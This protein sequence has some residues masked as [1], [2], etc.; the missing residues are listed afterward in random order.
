MK[1]KVDM[2]KYLTNGVYP[3]V[4]G[5]LEIMG[6]MKES[7][8]FSHDY[9]ARNDRKLIK[10]RMQFGWEGYG[11]FWAVVEVLREQCDYRIDVSDINGLAFEFKHDE[12]EFNDFIAFCLSDD[13]KLFETD[14]EYIWSDSLIRRMNHKET[15]R[16]LKSAGGKKGMANRWGDKKVKYADFVNMREK[17]YQKLVADH[18]EKDTKR[19]IEIL[20]NYKGSK[21]KVYKDDYRAILSW[22]VRKLQDEKINSKVGGNNGS[23]ST[24][25][26]SVQA[27]L[28]AR[29]KLEQEF[30]QA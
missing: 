19:M 9:N 23:A 15:I 13:V 27:K 29:N 17:D 28:E 26:T 8:Y 25:Q 5:L 24:A 1:G 10:V 30:L 20:D 18:G 12:K 22:V 11:L 16:Q 21:G 7:Y 14:G 6:E 4:D 3:L 2:Q